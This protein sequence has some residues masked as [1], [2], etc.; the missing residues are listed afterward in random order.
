MRNK[1]CRWL[2]LLPCLWGAGELHAQ[3]RQDTVTR[4]TMVG[5][6]VRQATVALQGR[7][8]GCGAGEEKETL[9]G[10]YI[11]IG[12]EQTPVTTTDVE[13]RFFLP[14]VPRGKV[15]VG[16]SYI[17]YEKLFFY[18]DLQKDTDVGEICLKSVLLDEVVV[19]AQVP[20]A[21]Q[22]GDTTKFNA[23]AV[24]LAP[25]ADLEAFIKKLPGFEIVDGKIMAQGKEVTH[26]YIDGQEYAFNDPGMALKDLPAKLVKKLAVFDKRSEEAEFSGYDDG[27]RYRSLNIETHE[28]NRP[29]V[30]G[31]GDAAYGVSSP[32][33]E[34]FRENSYVGVLAGSFFTPKHKLSFGADARNTGMR[35]DFPESRFG[36]GNGY[37]RGG[38]GHVN[39]SSRIGEKW[40]LSGNYR[41]GKNASESAA[42]SKQ[43]YFPTEHYETRVFDNESRSRN[44]G[45]SHSANVHAMCKVNRKNR[46]D[47]S[48][49]ASW[50]DSEGQ[51]LSYSA[52]VEDGDTISVAHTSNGNDGKRLNL[53]G[54]LTW[55]KSFAKQ[56]RTAT[57]NVQGTYS[58]NHS[59]QH[60]HHDERTL[61]EEG[62]YSD[63]V[64]HLSIG[65]R[66]RGYHF[67]CSGTW[68]EPLAERMRLAFN[69]AFWTDGDR[70]DRNSLAYRDEDFEELIGLDSAQTNELRNLRTSHAYG[71]NYSYAKEKLSFN[72]GLS[73]N[74]TRMDNR[75]RY[76][77]QADSTTV[78]R[79]VDLMP[80]LSLGL[81]DEKR[82]FDVNYSGSSSSPSVTQLQEV[83]DVQNPLQVS[84]GNPALKKSYSHNLSLS[85]GYAGV[86]N[87][88]FLYGTLH[89][90]QSFNSISTN[91]KFIDGDT[92]VNG[93]LLKRGASL[94]VPVNLNGNWN[95]AANVSYAFPWKKPKLNIH[96]SLGYSLSHTPSIYDDL[97]NMNTSHTGSVSGVFSTNFSEDFDG[98][99]G[100]SHSFSFS[101]NTETGSARYFNTSLNGSLSWVFW[102]G[103]YLQVYY[104]GRFSVDSKGTRVRQREHMLNPEIGRKFGKGRQMKLYVAA[105][106]VLQNRRTVHFSLSD[107][108]STTSY[109]TLPATLLKVGFTYRF[110]N[111]RKSKGRE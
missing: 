25:D 74:H 99:L 66:Q 55:M 7:V 90:G 13:G 51:S 94:S 72:T 57:F 41:L 31:Y 49:R 60:Q 19:E 71:V 79:Y 53:A 70:S 17:G 81:D 69:Y 45:W 46:L 26:I 50:G 102:K 78:S 91:T 34:T 44:E 96:T 22:H 6:T 56:G 110:D 101:N 18:L 65:S 73:L 80:M 109:Q 98:S 89:F 62:V 21:V 111:I 38:S 67:S 14:R 54:D 88:T 106:D 4:D 77:G 75:Y 84:K 63:T 28:P 92:V 24:V 16:A 33:K 27:K 87:S 82:H 2:C 15:Q 107:L 58:R 5:D 43:E 42:K 86:E 11:Y 40:D 68:S 10:A 76:P 29:K 104:S 36:N 83:L 9:P 12:D 52:N 8:V 93:Y 37:N 95:L 105:E 20:L 47:F 100:C 108:Y 48:T 35:V 30:F 103:V 85:Y 61:Q 3:V 1:G 97:K 64:R 32:V 39:V 23:E 59:G